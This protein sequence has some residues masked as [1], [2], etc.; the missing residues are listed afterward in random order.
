MDKEVLK[1]QLSDKLEQEI[2]NYKEELKKKI[3]DEI[4][5]SSYELVSK[6]EMIYKIVNKDYTTSELKALLKTNGILDEC[7]DEWLKS[8]GNFNELLEYAVD[9][10]IDVITEDYEQKMAQKNRESR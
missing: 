2:S 10:R 3:P 1:Q 4:L 9:R 6:E 8:D 5:K 7:Y